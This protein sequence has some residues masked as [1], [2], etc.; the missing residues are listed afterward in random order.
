MWDTYRPQL[1]STIFI[2][3]FRF[4]VMPIRCLLLAACLLACCAT[5]A[6]GQVL[7]PGFDVDEYATMLRISANQVDM[8]FRGEI[9]KELDYTRVYRSPEVG[10]HNKWDLWMSKDKSIMVVSLRGT[11]SD[12]DS[13][14]ENF[15]SAM[16][17]ATGSLK[18]DS[19]YTFNY[20]FANDPKAMVHVGWAIGTG[21]L[22]PTI[23]ARI[24]EYYEKGV[25][26]VIIEGHSQGG[27]LSFLVTSYLHYLVEDGKLP[28]DITFKT[29]C[30]AA[31][32]PGNLFYAYDFDYITRGG[33]AFTVVNTADW[34]PETPAS[35]QTVTDFN[36]INPFTATGEM[37]KKQ[38][39]IV[40]L[41]LKHV[42]NRLNKTLRKAQKAQQRYLGKMAYKQVK[43]YMPRLEKP[44]YTNS[45]NYARAGAPIVLQPGPDYYQRF[46]DTGNNIFRHHLFAPYYYL[47]KKTYK[48]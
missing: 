13:W 18:L 47:V 9:P 33:W 23:V 4:M 10:L 28:K 31:P 36:R 21:S 27:A 11:T 1:T 6:T 29:Y 37:V 44:E 19:N 12:M 20:K 8:Q 42:Y 39:W 26:Q 15:Y 46:P 34:V 30:S 40:R 3:T 32:K 45:N 35:I 24:K 38:K 41:A 17:P 48:K 16:I 5:P 7:Q 43:K 2:L 25:R 22:A 14:L